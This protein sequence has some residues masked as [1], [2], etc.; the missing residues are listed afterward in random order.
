MRSAPTLKSCMTPFSSVAML[1]ELALLKIAFCSAPAFS[2]AAS[3][4]S[5][6]RFTPRSSFSGFFAIWVICC[7]ASLV[8]RSSARH[9]WLEVRRGTCNQ[10]TILIGP[11][12]CFFLSLQGR[13]RLP[14]FDVSLLIPS[15]VPNPHKQRGLARQ[16]TMHTSMHASVTYH[17]YAAPAFSPALSLNINVPGVYISYPFC[18]QKCTY[19]TFASGVFPREIELCY[20]EALARESR[21][22][23]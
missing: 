7:S 9:S 21:A 18:A 20:R 16:E 14:R 5:S 8:S 12:G 23:V 19:C 13:R 2:S 11:P 6:S 10:Y 4:T 22:L 17:T 3:N 15:T 1:E